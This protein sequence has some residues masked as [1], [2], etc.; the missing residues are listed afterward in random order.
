MVVCKHYTSL[1][2]RG[3][4]PGFNIGF[5][6]LHLHCD[7]WMWNSKILMGPLGL[8]IHYSPKQ[9]LRQPFQNAL[10]HKALLKTVIFHYGTKRSWVSADHS[11][12]AA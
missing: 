9:G 5:S 7:P 8:K 2:L 6:S 11:L 12:R 4:V 3:R 10:P 1:S